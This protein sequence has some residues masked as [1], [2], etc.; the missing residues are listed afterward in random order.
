MNICTDRKVG[1]KSN[2]NKAI[3]YKMRRKKYNIYA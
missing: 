2:V 1:Y 3:K